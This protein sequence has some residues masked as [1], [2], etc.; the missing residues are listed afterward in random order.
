MDGGFSDHIIEPAVV[1]TL[2]H[3]IK[4]LE[5][6]G[7][8]GADRGGTDDRKQAVVVAAAAAQA[9]AGRRECHSWHTDQRTFEV[10]G[11]SPLG[12][13]GLQDSEDAG[14][15]FSAGAHPNQDQLA[16]RRIDAWE[17]DRLAR[18]DGAVENR[19]G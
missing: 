11:C 9:G 5:R 10:L 15:E 6:I 18:R 8:T 16:Q 14:V 3:R 1:R 19:A 13:R 12:T 17:V 7:E 4:Q 2:R